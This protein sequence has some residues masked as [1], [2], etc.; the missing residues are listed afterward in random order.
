M[1]VIKFFWER[2]HRYSQNGVERT[3][4]ENCSCI[5]TMTGIYIYYM[6]TCMQLN[7]NLLYTHNPSCT[8]IIII[9]MQGTWYKDTEINRIVVK[10]VQQ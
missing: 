6:Y 3:E 8:I 4:L 9:I 5:A 10:C 1:Q 7:F 2:M